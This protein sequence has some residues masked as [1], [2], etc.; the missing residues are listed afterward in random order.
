MTTVL[1]PMTYVTCAK[2]WHVQFSNPA[3]HLSIDIMSD[4][5]CVKVTRS[6]C[7][8]IGSW[9]YVA[10]RPQPTRR[11]S[12]KL[13]ANPGW[14]P[15]FPT[16]CQLVRN[17]SSQLFGDHDMQFGNLL[18]KWNVEND[19][20]CNKLPTIICQLVSSPKFQIRT[21]WQPGLATSF[22]LVRLVGCGLY[23]VR[24]IQVEKRRRTKQRW[25]LSSIRS[26]VTGQQRIL[27]EWE[28]WYDPWSQ[29]HSSSAD[30]PEEGDIRFTGGSAWLPGNHCLTC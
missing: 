9:Y 24:C 23:S 28:L 25:W 18:H 16:S 22:Q 4:R 11:T 20:A 19:Q 30:G 1:R 12:W 27:S 3:F 6:S 21:S 17:Y 2:L 15:G 26:Y 14:Q 29:L 10:L 5:W 13:V 7:V 8:H